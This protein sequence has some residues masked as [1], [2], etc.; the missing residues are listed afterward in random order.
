MSD[1]RADR[2][3]NLREDRQRSRGRDENSQTDEM[4]ETSDRSQA[5][6]TS[7]S[8]EK[9]KSSQKNQTSVRDQKHVAMYLEEDLADDLDMRFDELAL[10]YRREHGEKMEKNT[11]FYPALARAAINDTTLRDE[12]GLTE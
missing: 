12:L 10:E 7:V 6:N 9:D 1:E 4:S 5:S 11:D 2:V 3:R 8:D